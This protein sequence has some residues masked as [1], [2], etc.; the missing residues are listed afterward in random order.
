MQKPKEASFILLR[1]KISSSFKPIRTKKEAHFTLFAHPDEPNEIK[2]PPDSL[3]SRER[4]KK[5]EKETSVDRQAEKILAQ[6][7]QEAEEMKA[8]AY[9]EGLQLGITKGQEEGKKEALA[10][11]VPLNKTLKNLIEGIENTQTAILKKQEKEILHLCIQM[12]QK[13]IHTEIQQNSQILLA[14]LREGLQSVGRHKITAIKLNPHDLDLIQ[15]T[16]QDIPQSILNLKEVD[17]K[18]DPNLLPGGCLIQTD[19]GYV[20]A[21]IE[22]QFQELK[23]TFAESQGEANNES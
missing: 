18:A 13:I 22:N 6:A 2:T 12:A 23:K 7:K 21:S 4:E 20:D 17:F 14:N 5:K 9:Q 11:L 16:H 1:E 3:S 10:Q 15:N 19:L 8:K